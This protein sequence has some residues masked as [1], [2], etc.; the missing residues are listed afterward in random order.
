MSSYHM[1]HNALLC[2]PS[3]HDGADWSH[4]SCE[5]VHNNSKF[6]DFKLLTVNIFVVLLLSDVSFLSNCEL[7]WDLQ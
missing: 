5:H 6:S 1:D 4:C 7:I 2:P 3:S